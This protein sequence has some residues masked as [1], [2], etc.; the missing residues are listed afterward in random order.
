MR[1]VQSGSSVFPSYPL[2][3]ASFTL[4][5]AVASARPRRPRLFGRGLCTAS[6]Y[7]LDEE[8]GNVHERTNEAA[9]QLVLQILQL[10]RCPQAQKRVRTRT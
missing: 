8:V 10:Q 6:I 4:R 5:R 3:D 2:R 9:L 7:Y 1:T